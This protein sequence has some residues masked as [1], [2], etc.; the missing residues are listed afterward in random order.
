MQK[1]NNKPNIIF[2]TI[3]ALRARNLGC[4]GYHRNTSPNLD[5]YAKQGVLFEKFFSSYN[6]SHKSFL[7]ILSGR[8]VLGQ[9][10]EHYP[11]KREMKSFFDTGGIL[12]SEILQKNGYKTHFLRKL[13][14]WQ[15]IGFDYSLKQEAQEASKKWNIIRF[16][17][18]SNKIYNI[19]QYVLHNSYAIP[20]KLESKIRSNNT[21]ETAT[22]E[23]IEIIRQNKKNNFFLWLHYTDAHVPHIFPHSFSGKFTP[24]KESKRIFEIPEFNKRNKKDIGFLKACWKAKDTVED[25]IAKYDTAI[26]YDDCLISKIVDTLKEEDLLKD[27]IIFIFADHG[28]SLK[29][30]GLYFTHCGFYDTTFHI[31]LILFGKGILK[32]KRIKALTQL[33]DITPT[34]L[35]LA[36]IEYDPALFDGKSLVPLMTEEKDKIRESIFM[37]ERACGLIKR[38]IRTEKY[39]YSESPESGYSTCLLCNTNHGGTVN[40]YDLEK[41]PEE[42]INLA[43]EDK[44]ILI[45]MKSK[46]NKTIKDLKTTDEKRRIK[47]F[48]NKTLHR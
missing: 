41:D 40:L 29:E 30:H 43:K 3:D 24:K 2:I 14:G 28:E 19:A 7:S 34:I 37:E 36:K 18:K 45:K 9:D 8:H 26:S 22:N 1:K 13:F 27:T 12:L 4:Y 42:N 23:A 38:G 48:I 46:L 21:G 32:N 11:S 39:K 16:I 6:C 20:E 33:E 31:P 25:I 15:K 10:L 47:T 5:S 17:K 35:D 44:K